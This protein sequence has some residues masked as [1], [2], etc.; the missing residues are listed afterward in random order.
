MVV[1]MVAWKD[2]MMEIVM[3]VRLV[4]H[5]DTDHEKKRI[6]NIKNNNNC[7]VRIKYSVFVYDTETSEK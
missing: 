4:D 7:F 1:Q 6:F 2:A 5:G 3:V